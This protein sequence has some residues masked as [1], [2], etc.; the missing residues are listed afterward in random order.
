M[1]ILIFSFIRNGDTRFFLFVRNL[2]HIKSGFYL[3]IS[4][5]GSF[6]VAGKI[7]RKMKKGIRFATVVFW[8]GILLLPCLASSAAQR[9]DAGFFGEGNPLGLSADTLD[10][11]PGIFSVEETG[12]FRRFVHEVEVECRPGYVFPT[13]P[14]LKGWNFK[15]QSIRNFLALH[16]KYAFR[17]LPGSVADRIY[18]GVYQGV[19]VAGYTFGNRQEL[20][21]PFALYLFQGARI[22]RFSSRLSFHY[23]WNFGLSAAWKYYDPERNCYNVMMGSR[24]NACLHAG[25]YAAW[26]LSP[27]FDLQTGFGFTHFSNGNTRFPNAGINL[28]D[29]KVA[30]SCRLDDDKRMLSRKLEAIREIPAFPRHVCYELAV[31]GS[32]RRKGYFRGGEFVPSPKVYRVIGANFAALYNVGYR[33][34]AGLALDGV[35]D[36]SANVFVLND[37]SIPDGFVKPPFNAQIALGVSGRVEYVM[38]YFIVGVG[39]GTNVLHR[40]GDLEAFYQM[41]VLK[42]RM[43]RNLFLHIG[44][45]LQEFKTPNFLMLGIG[46]RFNN[47]YPKIR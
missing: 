4:F 32:W 29:L 41:L 36:A 30:L 17:Y 10:V 34:R 5:P 6:P 35:Y 8:G 43:T 14:F 45:N 7:V 3:C 12:R 37:S 26:R 9:E 42:M 39:M 19:G 22:F 44:Y 33:F 24:M 16:L 27:L 40:G 25:F 38:P 47:R 13:N 11:L 20:G 1:G 46:C 15:G 28:A 18:G 23:E 31:F 2:F 21:N